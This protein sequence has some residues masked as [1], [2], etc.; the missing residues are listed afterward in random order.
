MIFFT[1][2]THYFHTNVIKY[3]SRPFNNINEMNAALISNWNNV[4][5]KSDIVYHLGDVAFTKDA[6]S[7]IDIFK[8]LNGKKYLIYGNHDKF[9]RKQRDLLY[10]LFDNAYDILDIMHEGQSIVMS[11]YPMVEWNRGHYGSWML[12]GHCHGT[13][14]VT[15]FKRL[16]VGV[17]CFNYTPVS[18]EQVKIIMSTR[19]V[20]AHR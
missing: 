1:S 7:I 12:H 10:N 4:V 6:N 5:N 9:L 19:D 15:K 17:D 11:H 16:D 18:F 20:Y 13:L 3:S 14:P 8:Q 2:D